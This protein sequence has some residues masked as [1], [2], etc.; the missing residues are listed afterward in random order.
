MI[1]AKPAHRLIALGVFSLLMIVTRSHHIA[2]PLHLPDASVALFFL[3]GIVMQRRLG[4]LAAMIV[5]AGLID[6]WA[7][8][9]NGVSSF[10]ISSAYTMLLPTYALLW[11]G[12]DWVARR[13][14]AGHALLP[15]LAGSFLISSI[16]ANL[17][18]SGSFYLLSG[19]FGDPSLMTFLERMLQ[20]A[21][22]YVAYAAMYVAVATV[23]YLAFAPRGAKQLQGH[24]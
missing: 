7:I 12:G 5:G 11:F 8:N 23:G 4:Y 22:G 17:I 9:Y 21:P 19:R 14:D 16:G 15:S 2:T 6:F 20:Y 10:C 13:V 3:G 24:A 18:S 1:A